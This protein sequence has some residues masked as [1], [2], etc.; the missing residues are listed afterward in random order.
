MCTEEM[1]NTQ[2]GTDTM[3]RSNSDADRL[4]VHTEAGEQSSTTLYS[5]RNFPTTTQEICH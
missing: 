5:N 2:V 3:K 1:L 4:L